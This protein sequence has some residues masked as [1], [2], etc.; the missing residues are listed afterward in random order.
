MKRVLTWTKGLFGRWL[1]Q[2]RSPSH[3]YRIMVGRHGPSHTP[4][5]EVAHVLAA[6]HLEASGVVTMT[7]RRMPVHISPLTEQGRTEHA[8]LEHSRWAATLPESYTDHAQWQLSAPELSRS[9]VMPYLAIDGAAAAITFY[10]KA[11][12]ATELM[13]IPAPGGKVGHAEIEIHG[14]RIMLADEY[15]DMGFRNP[16][17]YGGTPM[18]LYLYVA[19]ADAVA[20]QAVAAGANELRPVQ[21]SISTGERTGTFQDPFGHVWCIATHEEDLP[22][23]ELKWRANQ[24]VMQHGVAGVSMN[25]RSR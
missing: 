15:L 1:G 16:K 18:T 6:K 12:G 7:I 24:N 17:A 3:H 21:R 19:D 2:D 13:R 20:R 5:L 14:S 4:Q 25:V 22:V 9:G 10:K 11:F 8:Q 23:D